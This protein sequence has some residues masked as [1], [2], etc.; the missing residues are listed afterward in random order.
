MKEMT[1][2]HCYQ[3]AH[4]DGD[5]HQTLQFVQRRRH[6]PELPDMEGVTNQEVCRAL[7]ARMQFLDKQAPSDINKD[8]IHHL[9]MVIILHEVRALIRKVEKGELHPEHILQGDDGHFKLQP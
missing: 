4:L 2:G 8:I 1:P 6:N 9:R 7:I 3:L 5:D